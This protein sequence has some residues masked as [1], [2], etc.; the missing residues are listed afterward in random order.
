[1]KLKLKKSVYGIM[2][3]AL[4]APILVGAQTEADRILL[5]IGTWIEALIPIVFA[6]ALLYFVWGVAKF[7]LNSADSGARE[8]G[9]QQMFWG[10]VALF[11]MTSVWGL[12]ALLG[13]S[14]NLNDPGNVDVPTFDAGT[15][16][17]S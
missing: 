4:F 7:I 16:Y 2:S 13:D 6:L 11:V 8:E 15:N 17:G 14:I 5:D 9:K 12:T 3:V 10:I 1:M